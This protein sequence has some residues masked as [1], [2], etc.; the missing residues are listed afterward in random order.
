MHLCPFPYFSLH[1]FPAPFPNLSS[2]I[3]FSPASEHSQLAFATVSSTPLNMTR[4]S[5]LGATL[6]ALLLPHLAAAS[7]RLP[8]SFRCGNEN[9]SWSASMHNQSLLLFAQQ[10]LSDAPVNNV[11]NNAPESGKPTSSPPDAGKATANTLTNTITITTSDAP[12]SPTA[13]S[14]A[15]PPEPR[16]PVPVYIHIVLDNL[17]AAAF[18]PSILDPIAWKQFFVLRD[19]F[20]AAGIDMSLEGGAFNRVV[21]DAGFAPAEKGQLETLGHD[22][23][24]G[25]NLT[26]FLAKNRKG[27]YDALNLFFF[28]RMPDNL[29]GV[30][31]F[32]HVKGITD[33]QIRGKDSC[34]VGLGN[35]PDKGL[36][37]KLGVKNK[38][39]G[40]TKGWAAVHEVGHWFGLMHSFEGRCE[41]PDDLV[42]DTPRQV[43]PNSFCIDPAR[44]LCDFKK[45]ANEGKKGKREDQFTEYNFM[46]Y[47]LDA[48]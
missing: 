47:G 32:P 33:E 18:P 30:C 27:G 28:S 29:A 9:P 37:E 11:I 44:L 46:D 16:I 12:T 43:L 25:S 14:G 22:L 34:I 35:F 1:F 2:C 38:A 8:P 48:W 21:G 40:K 7:P 17:T 39:P 3:H 41:G 24:Y 5:V 26:E 4:L 19:S 45:P 23:Q 10:D 36:Q 42:A 31:A 20:A 15:S 13:T 6:S